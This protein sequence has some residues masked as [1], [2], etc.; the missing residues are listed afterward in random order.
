M[1]TLVLSHIW[2]ILAKMRALILTLCYCYA[3]SAPAIFETAEQIV[4]SVLSLSDN[5]YEEAPYIQTK[6]DDE[7]YERNY[8]LK[9]WA[10]TKSSVEQLEDGQ[11]GTMFWKL[12]QYID[13]ENAEEKKIPMTVPV[14]TKVSGNGP[15]ELQMCFYINSEEQNNP[16]APTNPDVYIQQASRTIYTRTVGGYM[17]IRSWQTESEYVQSKLQS[18]GLSIDSSR[19]WKVGYDAPFKFWNRRNEV[20]YE[21]AYRPRRITHAR[22]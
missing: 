16:P 15:Y 13:G 3:N 18:L 19:Y 5:T 21:K 8:A 17:N 9:K 10:C 1:G 14:T 22:F 11:Q 4:S 7:M 20:W 12:F 2:Q 6:L